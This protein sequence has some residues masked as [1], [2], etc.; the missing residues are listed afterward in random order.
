MMLEPDREAAIALGIEIDRNRPSEGCRDPD[1]AGPFGHDRTF[2]ELGSAVKNTLSHRARALRALSLK[3]GDAV[4]VF[5]GLHLDEGEGRFGA[6]L[7]GVLLGDDDRDDLPGPFDGALPILD[8]VSGDFVTTALGP[9]LTPTT[10]AERELGLS[11]SEL[12]QELG[13]PGAVE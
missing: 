6:E 5:T 10:L 7:D 12:L 3:L 11:T 9:E 2:A 1:N 13:E 8:V 4:D